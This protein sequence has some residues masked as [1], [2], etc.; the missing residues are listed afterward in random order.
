MLKKSF[1]TKAIHSG[2]NATS[3]LGS[4]SPPIFQ[5]ASYS[6]DSAEIG[7]ASFAGEVDAYVY[8][9]MSNPTVDILQKRIAE[10]ENGEQGLAFASGMA[11]I[12]ASIIALTKANDH[13][14]CSSGLYGA[15]YGL[16][17]TL[18]EK[19][20][21]AVEFSN[22]DSE[23]TIES[24]I[25]ENTSCIYIET[26]INPTMTLIDLQ[27]V[28]KVANKYQIPVIVDN[29]FSSPY[30]Q[31]PLEL[32]CDLVIHSATKYLNGHGDV[33]AGLAAGKKQYIE[34]IAAINE[35]GIGAVLSPLN[36]WLLLRGLKTL[37]VRMEAH[38]NNA[39]KIVEKL[40]N[41]PKIESIYYP[42]DDPIFSKQ[43]KRGGGVISF[44]VK[45]DKKAAQL[46][47][48]KLQFIKLAVSLGDAETL[49]QHPA[50]MTHAI[51]PEEERVNMQITDN[52][53]RLSV[54]LE[55]VEDIWEDLAQALTYI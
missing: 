20:N 8:A 39:E 25:K 38:C 34:K 17:M 46:F 37:P 23:A 5:T 18:Q 27:L 41:H 7:E 47:L 45:G 40:Q 49:I 26:P 29:T 35:K 48:N 54:G 19:Y 22:L 14:L 32:G 55:S 30:L 24:Q 51:I 13:I 44:T 21:I 3:T 12:S 16:F 28:T 6:F 33:I 36:A 43:M 50:S 11:A 10:L 53:L 9:R 15:T 31:R 52:L 1:E 42:T 4:I 2:Y